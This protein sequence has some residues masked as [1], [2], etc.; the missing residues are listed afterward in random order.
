MKLFAF[1]IGY[2]VKA[3]LRG[4]ANDWTQ[5]AGT[6]RSAEKAS[7]LAKSIRNLE[8]F[9]FGGE[10]A[11]PGLIE[12]LKEAD[13]LL[14]SVPPRGHDLVLARFAAE[15]AN[16]NVARIVYL[17]TIGVYGG[18][19]G[20]WV[21]ETT[22]PAGRIERARARIAAENEWLALAR[23]DRRVFV[24][25]LAG[26]YGVGRN[27]LVNLRDGT[28]KRIVR[29]GQV[30]NRI[31]TDD[32]AQAISACFATSH[33]GGVFNV[34]DDEPAPP[35]DVVAYGAGLL[36]VPPPAEIPFE[37]ADLSPMARSFWASNKRV[38]NRKLKQELGI[39]LRYPTY[40]EGLA[41]LRQTLDA[42][43]SMAN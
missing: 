22:P 7:R 16:S 39:K 19:D 2:S 37:Q 25:R 33:I 8:A 23:P 3:Y 15:I 14:I 28:A 24:L 12:R 32:I 31:H 30:F 11:E 40:R 6:V 9:A 29:S 27:A 13:A 4:H 26:I 17:S 34:C 41:A 38:S 21:D 20:G 35:Q 43:E 18:D 36:S 1:G 42:D 5:M 10:G